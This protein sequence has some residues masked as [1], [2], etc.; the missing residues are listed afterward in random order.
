MN[1]PG[2]SCVIVKRIEERNTERFHLDVFSGTSIPEGSRHPPRAESYI[3][4][5]N[6]WCE[7]KPQFTHVHISGGHHKGHNHRSMFPNV[8]KLLLVKNVFAP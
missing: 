1:V 3:L 6:D 5:T 4:F 7:E 2:V 8:T